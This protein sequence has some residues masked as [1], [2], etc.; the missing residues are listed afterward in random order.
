M[1]DYKRNKWLQAFT[2]ADKVYPTI[3]TVG[4]R[5]RIELNP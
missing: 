4:Y 3:L 1:M 2:A 5:Q